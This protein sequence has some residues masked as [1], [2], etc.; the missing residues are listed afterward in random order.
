MSIGKDI[1]HALGL[2]YNPDTDAV[3]LPDIMP[4]R[5]PARVQTND[6]ADD[7]VKGQ[8]GILYKP[9][10]DEAGQF[11]ISYRIWKGER[12]RTTPDN[13]GEALEERCRQMGVKVS[14]VLRIK[15]LF[16]KGLTQAQV[17]EALESEQGFGLR[18]VQKAWAVLAP[19][20]PGK[21]RGPHG[22]RKNVKLRKSVLKISKL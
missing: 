16:E 19:I 3:P 2:W 7:I 22:T 12:G 21:E 15:P 1:L 20:D 4:D 13:L 9:E 17:V 18:T 5:K 10:K 11:N 8:S 14:T 6:L